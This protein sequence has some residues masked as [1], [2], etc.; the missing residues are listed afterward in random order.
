M[1]SC[2]TNNLRACVSR[3]LAACYSLE[4]RKKGDPVAAG[5]DGGLHRLRWPVGHRE[6]AETVGLSLAGVVGRSLGPARRRR[7]RRDGI[8]PLELF[9]APLVL[10][11][12]VIGE[13]VEVMLAAWSLCV[14]EVLAG[15]SSARKGGELAGLLFGG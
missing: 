3:S 2:C 15:G 4:R 11:S 6:V 13:L 1:A 9:L 14:Q 8:S 10:L 5:R 12:D 7:R